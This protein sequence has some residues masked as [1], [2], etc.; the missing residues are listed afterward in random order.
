MAKKLQ[1]QEVEECKEC[2]IEILNTGAFL[3]APTEA[4][5]PTSLASGCS[6]SEAP[7]ARIPIQADYCPQA[8]PVPQL[9]TPPASSNC[10]SQ[11]GEDLSEVMDVE[12]DETF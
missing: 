7:P 10:F 1:S 5:A 11:R 6:P 8:A 12:R 2:C 4:D 3:D 9:V